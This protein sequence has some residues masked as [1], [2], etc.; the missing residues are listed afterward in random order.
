MQNQVRAEFAGIE[1]LGADQGAHAGTMEGF[2]ETLRQQ[3]AVALN[4]LDGGM[5]S[6]EHQACMRKVD[7]LIDAHIAATQDY[8]RTTG[9]VGDTFLAGGRQAQGFFAG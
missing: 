8:R 2:R 9:V 5:G 6:D 7:E 4:D 3:A 1:Q